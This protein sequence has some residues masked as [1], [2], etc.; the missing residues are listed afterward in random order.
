M[1]RSPNGMH[2]AALLFEGEIRF[3]PEYFRL[4]IDARAIPHRI[5]GRPLQWSADSRFIA[6]QEWLTTDYAAGPI[7][8]AALIDADAWKIARLSVV[9]KGF[10]EDFRFGDGVLAYRQSFPAQ[11]TACEADVILHSIHSWED[12]DTRPRPS[13]GA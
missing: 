7:T 10:A 8:C 6:A 4:A 2:R 1:A 5:F 13:E 11:A 12:I 9:H 3:G